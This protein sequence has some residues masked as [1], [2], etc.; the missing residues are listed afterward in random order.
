MVRDSKRGRTRCFTNW[1][2]AL[3][4]DNISHSLPCLFGRCT[5]HGNRWRQ[6][7]PQPSVT[8]STDGFNYPGI[9]FQLIL[10]LFY[11]RLEWLSQW[12]SFSRR[13]NNR[14]ES[15]DPILFY[16]SIVSTKILLYPYWQLLTMSF[17][18]RRDS[19]STNQ[20]VPLFI[21]L[22]VD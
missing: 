16:D 20:V 4:F 8:H 18:S 6:D 3:N 1:K 7:A 22:P 17:L 19:R 2:P 9:L 12:S 11:F 5:L 15:T 13:L 21:Q 14:N 10:F